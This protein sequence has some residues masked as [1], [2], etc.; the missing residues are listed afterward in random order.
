MGQ[1]FKIARAF[2]NAIFETGYDNDWMNRPEGNGCITEKEKQQ[3]VYSIMKQMRGTCNPKDIKYFV[4][5][6]YGI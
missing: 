5:M 3:I 4:D 2:E 1:F 6:E